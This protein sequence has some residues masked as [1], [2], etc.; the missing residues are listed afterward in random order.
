MTKLRGTGFGEGPF[1]YLRSY[2]FCPYPPLR[3]TPSPATTGQGQG[4]IAREGEKG[5]TGWWGIGLPG[6]AGVG[7]VEDVWVCKCYRRFCPINCGPLS[8]H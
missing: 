3:C 8:E 1:G 5:K 4:Q 6:A 2:L 7:Q